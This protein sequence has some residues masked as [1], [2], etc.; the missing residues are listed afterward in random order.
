MFIP[1][2]HCR[3]T[4]MNGRFDVHGNPV[5]GA[6]RTVQCAVVKIAETRVK[7][8]VRTDSSASRG[9]AHESSVS[10]RLLFLAGE[11]I[12]EGDLIEFRNYKLKVTG[13][14]PMYSVNGAPDHNQ[15][16]AETWS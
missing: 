6:I 14:S 7:T 8:S 12:C 3:I 11:V 13:V 15:I 1:N 5:P 2:T 10:A 9:F 4:D 16:D